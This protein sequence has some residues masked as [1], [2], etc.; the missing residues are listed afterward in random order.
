VICEDW[1]EQQIGQN[2][3]PGKKN[4]K[5]FRSIYAITMGIISYAEFAVWS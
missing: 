5:P 2:Q 3:L 4:Q 1:Q